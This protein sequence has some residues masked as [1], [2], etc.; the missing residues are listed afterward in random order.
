[1]VRIIRSGVSGRLQAGH[2][3]EATRCTEKSCHW[4]CGL[5]ADGLDDGGDIV[6]LVVASLSILIAEAG[7]VV[8]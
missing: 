1:V 6:V 7:A 2:W 4:R 5:E 3:A 8:V